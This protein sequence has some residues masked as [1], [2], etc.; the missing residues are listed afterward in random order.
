MTTMTAVERLVR[1]REGEFFNRSV[2]EYP[3]YLKAEA[4][5]VRDLLA[6]PRPLEDEDVAR[7]TLAITSTEVR[8]VAWA[9]MTVDTATMW[10]E[11]WLDVV[12]RVPRHLGA[13]PASLLAFAAWLVGTPGSRQ[14]AADACAAALDLDPRYRMAHL[15]RTALVSGMP[16]HMWEPPAMDELPL[17]MK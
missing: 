12:T 13:A 7:L 11:F 17:M 8:D 3:H 16:S 6:D 2:I 15:V 9:S 5:W 4:L 1:E 10:L 14:L